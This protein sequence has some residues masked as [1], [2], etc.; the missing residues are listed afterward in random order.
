MPIRTP[1]ARRLLVGLAIPVLAL[2]AG[3]CSSSEPVATTGRSTSVASATSASDPST[4]VVGTDPSVPDVT[5]DGPATDAAPEPIGE[6][7]TV[8]AQLTKASA[9][10]YA[11]AKDTAKVVTTLGSSTALGS[12]T[13]LLVLDQ[14]DGWVHVSL[15]VR[16]NGSTGW[17]KA[18]DVE[19]RSNPMAI[20]VDR[21]AH[22]LTLTHDGDVVLTTS[23]AVGSKQNPT[24]PGAFFVTDLID[25][26][27]P[28]S[29]YGPFAFGLSGHSDTLSEFGGGDG[30]LGVH[31]T[32]D[33]SSIGKSVSHG[34]VRVPNAIIEQ[35]A[36]IVPLGT[37]V[38]IS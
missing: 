6:H 17:L 13:T 2:S 4:S 1:F 9:K 16:P 26:D 25:T 15:P 23:V 36:E 30:Q 3:A 21:A 33:P 7:E 19:L 37:P 10:V 11:D 27:S 29:A 32:D 31:G 12:K 24:P 14:R 38:T 22:T 34:C 18:D 20:V 5:V 8:A 35:L 28:S